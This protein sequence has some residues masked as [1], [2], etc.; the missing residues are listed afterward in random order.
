MGASTAAFAGS[1]NAECVPRGRH[2]RRAPSRGMVP[3][4][5]VIVPAGETRQIRWSAVSAV[6]PRRPLTACLRASG[7]SSAR[8]SQWTSRASIRRQRPDARFRPGKRA[9]EHAGRVLTRI[10]QGER[11]V[12]PGGILLP[13]RSRRQRPRESCYGSASSKAAQSAA[14]RRTSSHVSPPGSWVPASPDEVANITEPVGVRRA[15]VALWP[16]QSEPAE[17]SWIARAGG[18]WRAAR[19]ASCLRTAFAR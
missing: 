2:L 19:S 8:R 11:V 9:S 12:S 5:V 15:G 4:T 1:T 13:H 17:R 16:A 6:G 10:V 7:Q 18:P 14:T 3:G